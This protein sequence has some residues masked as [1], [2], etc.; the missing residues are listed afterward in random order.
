MKYEKSSQRSLADQDYQS[1]N[2][3]FDGKRLSRHTAQ[4]KLNKHDTSQIQEEKKAKK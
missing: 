2:D 4:A 1:L 3:S